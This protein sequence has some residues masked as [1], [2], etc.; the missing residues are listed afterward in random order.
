MTPTFLRFHNAKHGTS[1]S[2]DQMS[3][4]YINDITGETNEQMLTKIEAYLS[5]E[6][7][8]KG[9][10]IAGAVEAIQKLRDS[11]TLVIITSRDE[12]FRGHTEA[13]IE[14]HF[15]GLF[16][17]LRYSHTRGQRG[18]YV[19]KFRICQE[20][21][22]TAIVDDNLNTIIQ[23]ADQGIDCVLF[24][25]YAWNQIDSLPP[26]VV[27]CLDWPAVLKHFTPE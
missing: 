11:Y 12:F 19:P 24:G 6:H 25:N 2:L 18:I 20:V 5:T 13:F 17:E 15:S 22:A 4:N 7:F 1:I 23:C 3:T 14:R 26:R 10:P 9:Q 27:R 16:D 21:D 8:Q